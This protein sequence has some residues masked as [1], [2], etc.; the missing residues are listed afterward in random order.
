[1]TPA[2]ASAGVGLLALAAWLHD[3][4]VAELYLRTDS[5]V[6]V[7]G[8]LAINTL[9]LLLVVVLLRRGLRPPVSLAVIRSAVLLVA[10]MVVLTSARMAL[11]SVTFSMPVRLGLGGLLMLLS[12]VT[13]WL[14]SEALNVRLMRSIG[15]ASI[16][17]MAVPLLWH[18]T[19]GRQITWIDAEVS[20]VG[21]Q[22]SGSRP[23]R[24]TVFLL[25]DELSFDAARPI[26]QTLQGVGL[27]VDARPLAPVAINTTN[28][29]PS[30]FSG[31]RFDRAEPC[32]RSTICSGAAFVDFS[33]VHVDRPDVH[34][35]G[36]LHPYCDMT[37]LQSC[38][39]LAL[40]HTY[41]NAYRSLLAFYLRRLWPAGA[42]ALQVAD[43]PAMVRGFLAQQQAF[44]DGSRFWQDGGVLY[45]HLYLPHPPG[46]DG[47]T[48]VDADYAANL[49]VAAGLVRSLADRLKARFGVHFTLMITSDH[50]LR[51]SWC[52]HPL[53]PRGDC[54]LRPAFQGATVPWILASPTPL[55]V[56]DIRA[57]NQVFGALRAVLRAPTP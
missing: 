22:A 1:M 13:A 29:I 38:H 43:P 23:L 35:T 12:V 50:P 25:L 37:G 41:G 56:Q 3:W 6:H 20:P 24:G 44:I 36:L 49:D 40:P 9:L 52:Q 10:I 53:Y 5:A 19:V 47:P 54:S 15:F 8:A 32:G 30:M 46:L 55:P 21:S 45:A 14:G 4:V 51:A 34:V 27:Q 2:L 26:V 28:A 39:Q 57:S 31:E 42:A 7:A 11:G 16:A 17:F 48:S 33:R 18:V